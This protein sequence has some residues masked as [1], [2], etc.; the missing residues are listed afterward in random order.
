MLDFSG[1]YRG[2]S[3][4][5]GFGN[6]TMLHL[7][8]VVPINSMFVI[9]NFVGLNVNK[10]MQFRP[11]EN[12]GLIVSLPTPGP[13]EVLWTS[14]N[15]QTSGF[16]SIDG[17]SLFHVGEGET[18]IAARVD[19]EIQAASTTKGVNL[20]AIIGG[21]VGG[22]VVL[23]IIVGFVVWRMTRFMLPEGDQR[24]EPMLDQDEEE[25]PVPLASEPPDP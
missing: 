24:A 13:Y 12:M 6:K 2:D 20:G 4:T 10:T 22:I 15:E 11:R 17:S 7:R 3:V 23:S 21:A 16:L 1:Q 8:E 14:V 18:F 19:M 5:D 25:A 9:L